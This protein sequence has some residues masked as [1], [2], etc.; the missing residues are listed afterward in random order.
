MRLE[1][2][3]AAPSARTES[4]HPVQ[5]WDDAVPS[6]AADAVFTVGRQVAALSALAPY[7]SE[8]ER[9]DS[10]SAVEQLA[11]ELLVLAGTP[12]PGVGDA[13]QVDDEV[14]GGE[15]AP[16]DVTPTGGVGPTGGAGPTG[17]VAPDGGLAP[18]TRVALDQASGAVAQLDALRRSAVVS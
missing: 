8:A 2:V 16:D 9:E 12:Q 1:F 13:V 10:R 15:V 6:P 14:T 7:W 5:R 4:P 18:D 11:R 17:D 3:N